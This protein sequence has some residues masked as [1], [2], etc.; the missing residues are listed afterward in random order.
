MAFQ[1]KIKW[2]GHSQPF[3]YRIAS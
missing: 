3:S 1:A 2:K